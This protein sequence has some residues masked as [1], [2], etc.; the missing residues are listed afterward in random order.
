MKSDEIIFLHGSHI[1]QC[2]THVAKHFDGY[3]SLQY[4]TRGGVELFYDNVRHELAPHMFWP[5]SPGP[6]I[7]FHPNKPHKHWEH[8]YV[9][10]RGPLAVRWISEGLLP[11]KPLTGLRNR[12]YSKQMDDLIHLAHQPTPLAHR[13]A[14]NILEGI[15]LELAE[16]SILVQPTRKTW[17]DQV[18]EVITDPKNYPVDYDALAASMNMAT[19]TLRRRFRMAADMPIH[20]YTLL[21]RLTKAQH[22]LV[23]TDLPIKHISAQLGFRDVYFFTRQ[24]TKHL[25][26]PPGKFRKSR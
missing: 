9:A 6:F 19:S 15:L 12:N 8:R 17:L 14:V 18:L 25:G 2:D 4:I 7:R 10:F 1:P 26:L 20:S 3:C 22:L 11:L 23:D 13:R 24:F 16:A 21:A 5:C